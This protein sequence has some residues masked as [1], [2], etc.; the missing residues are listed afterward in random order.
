MNPDIRSL[1]FSFDVLGL[2]WSIQLRVIRST[3]EESPKV[4]WECRAEAAPVVLPETSNQR[5][6]QGEQLMVCQTPI[7]K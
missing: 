2:Q 5:G 1:L 4:A 6:R 3:H 7:A